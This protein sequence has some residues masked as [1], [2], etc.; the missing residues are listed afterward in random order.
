MDSTSTSTDRLDELLRRCQR[1]EAVNRRQ[2]KLILGLTAAVSALLAVE[3]LQYAGMVH[4]CR[5][6]YQALQENDEG[7]RQAQ[8]DAAAAQKAAEERQAGFRL[9][10]LQAVQAVWTFQQRQTVTLWQ[11]NVDKAEQQL[12]QDIEGEQV[13]DQ[14]YFSLPGDE[15]EDQ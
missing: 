5:D 12:R 3:A 9:V 13:P 8:A 6:M 11:L 15:P 2:R 14:M 1:A 10:R 4:K 7:L